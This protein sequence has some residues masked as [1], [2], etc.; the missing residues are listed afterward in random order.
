LCSKI[1]G[2]TAPRGDGNQPK[3]EGKENPR[4]STSAA[5]ASQRTMLSAEVPG[6]IHRATGQENARLATG[7]LPPGQN[8]G[9]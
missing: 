7:Y 4:E 1:V 9:M 2:K 5:S 6:R 3:S 8:L